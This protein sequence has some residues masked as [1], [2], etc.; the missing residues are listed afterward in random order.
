MFRKIFAV[1]WLALACLAILA[2]P[3]SANVLQSATATANCQG[4]NLTAVAHN[5]GIGTTY[6]INYNFVLT[7][8]GGSPVNV[9]GTIVFKATAHVM[10]VSQSG[11]FPGLAGTCTVT[12]TAVLVDKFPKTIPVVVNGVAVAPLTC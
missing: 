11:T 3:A 2:T 9:P 8:N 4:Y 7:C 12:G 6:T 1:L 5:L 10:T